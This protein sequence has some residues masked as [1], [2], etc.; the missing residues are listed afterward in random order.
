MFSAK[1]LMETS[2]TSTLPPVTVSGTI[3][4]M[5]ITGP[6]WQMSGGSLP[7]NKVCV[8]AYWDCG[9]SIARFGRPGLVFTN[10]LILRIVLYL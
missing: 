3:R 5:S 7:Q 2:T 10:I 4:V 1:I 6:W 8:G 9:L